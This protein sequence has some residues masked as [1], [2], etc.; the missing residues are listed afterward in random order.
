MNQMTTVIPN[1]L[2]R[3]WR[4][5]RYPDNSKDVD[6]ATV[7]AWIR[8]AREAGVRTILC[9]LDEKQL[10]YYRQLGEGGLLGRYRAAGFEVI[11]RPSE[12][13]QPV[14]GKLLARIASD[15]RSATLPMLVHCSAG[16]GRTGAVVDYLTQ[17]T[18]LPTSHGKDQT[19]RISRNV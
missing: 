1:V 4:P 6:V 3:S 15:F 8:E 17:S 14:S 13:Y 19:R 12:D 9:L 5:G 18:R 10:G 11:H 16:V 2:M 7:D